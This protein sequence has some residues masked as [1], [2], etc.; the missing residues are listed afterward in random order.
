MLFQA[1]YFSS[2]LTF[3]VNESHIRVVLM[4]ASGLIP[5]NRW[6]GLTA[7][8]FVDTKVDAWQDVCVDT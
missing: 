7:F 2:Y 3:Y 1:V 4:A 6:G 8:P 5:G